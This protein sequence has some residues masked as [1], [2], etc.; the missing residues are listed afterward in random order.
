MTGPRG[1]KMVTRIRD[2]TRVLLLLPAA[3]LSPAHAKAKNDVL[4]DR[5]DAFAGFGAQ[6]TGGER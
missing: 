3:L 1:A 4:L 2:M 5:D 6:S